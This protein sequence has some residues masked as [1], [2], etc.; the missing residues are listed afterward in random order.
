[1]ATFTAGTTPGVNFASMFPGFFDEPFVVA[2]TAAGRFSIQYLS[3]ANIVTFVSDGSTFTYNAADPTGGTFDQ[4][5]LKDV[6]GTE[7]GRCRLA[8]D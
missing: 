5:I 2:E 7:L 1:M 3:G 8:A 6:T 4:I